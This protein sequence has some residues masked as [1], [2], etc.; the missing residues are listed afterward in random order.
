M[1][2]LFKDD[3][4]WCKSIVAKLCREKQFYLDDDLF[5]V[6]YYALHKASMR[7]HGT[8]RRQFQTYAWQRIRGAIIDHIRAETGYRTKLGPVQLVS[9]DSLYVERRLAIDGSEERAIIRDFYSKFLLSLTYEEA[10]IVDK[11]FKE[12]YSNVEISRMC[13][14]TPARISQILFEARKKA[15]KLWYNA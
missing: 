12:G 4:A 3:L 9:L 10:Y 8:S 11:S 15:E 13:Y 1:Y 14:L 6:G 7:F 5:S 2:P